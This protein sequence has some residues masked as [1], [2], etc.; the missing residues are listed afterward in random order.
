MKLDPASL[1][2][3]VRRTIER[4]VRPLRSLEQVVRWAFSRTPPSAIADVIVRDE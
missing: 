1:P 2:E 4:E 3:E